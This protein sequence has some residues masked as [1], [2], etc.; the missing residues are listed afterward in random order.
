MGLEAAPEQSPITHTAYENGVQSLRFRNADGSESSIGVIPPGTYDFGIATRA[1]HVRG[2][3]GTLELGDDSK[4]TALPIPGGFTFPK[5]TRITFVVT[6]APAAYLCDYEDD[7][8]A[9]QK[10]QS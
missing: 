9:D 4:E 10:P 1:E 6:E 3:K 7:S 2:M 5:G 8:P